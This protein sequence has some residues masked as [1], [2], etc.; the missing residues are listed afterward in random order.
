MDGTYPTFDRDVHGV[1]LGDRLGRLTHLETVFT[2]LA[3]EFP[4]NTHLAMQADAVR[5][6]TECLRRVAV[7]K[8]PFATDY[9]EE[10][11]EAAA[12][13]QLIGAGEADL[14]ALDLA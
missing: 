12:L 9:A 10:L 14:R 11:E 4:G 8:G 6:A 1:T 7:E 5:G 2:G 3:K 13:F